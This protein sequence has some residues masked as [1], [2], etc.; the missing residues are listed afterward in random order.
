MSLSRSAGREEVGT[1]GQKADVPQSPESSRLHLLLTVAA[2]VAWGGSWNTRKLR[3]SR[4]HGFGQSPTGQGLLP[5]LVSTVGIA[6]GS[7][8]RVFC[9]A[10]DPVPFSA[11]GSCP[12]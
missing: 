10:S 8:L 4:V 6:C 9:S 7:L 11:F 1:A 3:D 5:L 12:A 2:N